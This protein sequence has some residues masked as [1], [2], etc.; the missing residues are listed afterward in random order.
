MPMSHFP[1]E[2]LFR[3]LYCAQPVRGLH[4]AFRLGV[5]SLAQQADMPVATLGPPDT[6]TIVSIE[7]KAHGWAHLRVA[8]Q[9]KLGETATPG[10]D[11]KVQKAVA[12]L[13]PPLAS[14]EDTDPSHGPGPGSAGT[15]IS[16]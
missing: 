15:T 7:L 2:S 8:G 16:G 4:R 10:M 1:G 3:P 9:G 13:P 12:S 6:I 14:P 5:V 11:V